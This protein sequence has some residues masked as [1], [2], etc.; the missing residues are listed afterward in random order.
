M[1]FEEA[2]TEQATRRA[3][4]DA[5]SVA[6]NTFPKDG[7]MGLTP[8]AVKFTPEFRQARAEYNHAF[9]ELRIF[10][11][12]MLRTFAKECREERRNRRVA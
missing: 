2:K 11:S 4:A 9:E 12:F 5:T 8:D 6:L 1:T 3:R 7:P 10:N